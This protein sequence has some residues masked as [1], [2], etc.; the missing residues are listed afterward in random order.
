MSG[1]HHRFVPVDRAAAAAIAEVHADCFVKAWSADS[2]A[3]LFAVP[4]TLGWLAIERDGRP[5]GTLM[6]RTVAGQ[7]DILTLAV[8]PAAR[9][10]GLATGLLGLA[11]QALC[12]PEPVDLF[13]EVAESNAAAIAL[14]RAMGFAESGRRRNYYTE[15]GTPIDALVMCKMAADQ[16]RSIHKR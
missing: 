5:D 6:I 10:Q 4:G 8:R 2:V 13:L 11:E 1:E 16:A 3:A 7:A 12:H 14:Y 15:A 9:R